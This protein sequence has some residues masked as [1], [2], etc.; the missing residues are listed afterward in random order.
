[1]PAL[2][3]T[4]APLPQSP[5]S[6][7]PAASADPEGAGAPGL[8]GAAATLAPVTALAPVNALAPLLPALPAQPAGAPAAAAGPRRATRPVLF[9]ALTLVAALIALLL[10]D[11]AL[12]ALL[13]GSLSEALPSFYR[14]LFTEFLL[15]PWFYGVFAGIV[16]L[17]RLLPASPAQPLLATGVRN[18]FS[19]IFLKLFLGALVVPLWVVLLR[20]VYGRY[21]QVLT[22]HWVDN[23][24]RLARILLAVLFADLAFWVTHVVRHKVSYLWYFHAVHHSQREL[25]FFTEYRVHPVDDIFLFTIG[26]IP[27]FMLEHSFVTVVAIVWVRH[28]HTRFYHSNIRTNLGP[29]R[30]ILVTPQSHRVHHSVEPRHHDKNFGLTFSLWDHLFGTQ[31]R[32][33]DEYP[34]TGIDDETFPHEQNGLT[35][36]GATTLVEQLLYPFRAIARQAR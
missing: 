17:E 11:P 5:A 35:P 23:W 15:N 19:W 7:V 12:M 21:L 16:L 1:M 10:R 34:A 3:W 2:H 14:T 36:G 27:L 30:Y 33:Y 22:I 4:N 24:P 29:L 28:W 8:A 26:F 32:G 13:R 18:D 20:Y 25:N 9:A 6:P 31:Y